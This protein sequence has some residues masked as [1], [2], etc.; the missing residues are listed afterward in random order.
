MPVFLI[1]L[2]SIVAF[3]VLLLILPVHAVLSYKDKVALRIY[4]LGVPVWRLPRRQKPPNPRD[5]TVKKIRRREE[6]AARKAAKKAAKAA[7]KL[8][9][10]EKHTAE[11]RETPRTLLENLRLVRALVASLLRATDKHLSLRTARLTVRVVGEDAA[12]TAILYGAVAASLSYLFSALDRVTRLS[13]SRSV[14]GAV[15]DYTASA[16]SADVKLVFSISPWR[17]FALLFSVALAFVKAKRLEKRRQQ[18]KTAT[19]VATKG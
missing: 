13:F 11:H 14:I 6:K 12:A 3:L 17:A 2:L 5:Y 10:K 4:V 16:P 9:K 15:A 7:K 18:Q 19:D 8:A 1:V